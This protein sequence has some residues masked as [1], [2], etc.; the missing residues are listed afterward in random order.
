MGKPSSPSLHETLKSLG[1]QDNDLSNSSEDVK[2]NN[3]YY[4]NEFK[5]NNYNEE[6]V[7]RD[8]I[9]KNN[10]REMN[11][12][13]DGLKRNKCDDEEIKNI[14]N[15]EKKAKVDN[16]HL[17]INSDVFDKLANK[18]KKNKKAKFL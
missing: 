1:V 17:N 16:N 3:N 11:I 10:S 8:I 6:Y 12:T 5:N 4:N 14:N 13:H 7:K 2:E 15:E 9:G 18:N